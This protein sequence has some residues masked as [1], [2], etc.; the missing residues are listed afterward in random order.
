[1]AET[2]IEWAHFTFNPWRGCTKVSAGCQNCYADTMSK[3]NP[4]TLGVWGP[5]GKR[6]VAAE[7][8]WRLPLKWNREAAERQ[9]NHRLAVMTCRSE[10]D[11]V[12][13]YERPR[14]FCASL[15]DVFESWD[16]RIHDTSG[17]VMYRSA[18]GGWLSSGPS[19]HSSLMRIDDVRARLFRLIDSTPNL[20]WLLLTKR[21][22]NIRRMWLNSVGNGEYAHC[23]S[24]FGRRNVWLLTSVEDQENA[25]KR[26]PELLKCRDLAPVLGLSCEPL[27]GPVDLQRSCCLACPNRGKGC[28][29]GDK[30]TERLIVQSDEG[31][32]LQECYCSRLNKLHWVIAGGESGPGARQC[33][34][35]WIRSIVKQCAAAGVACFVKQLGSKIVIRNDS[36]SEWPRGGDGLLDCDDWRS[37]RTF[38]GDDAMVRSEDRKGGDPDEWPEDLRVREF[39]ERAG[40]KCQP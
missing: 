26:I 12:E 22:E 39:P 33:H 36:F 9:D 20:D 5:Q 18:T 2:K 15:A 11:S 35:G 30:T 10:Y 21:P 38:Q 40:V 14:V 34:V 24:E 8:Y 37:R 29:P 32:I 23:D 13:P 31:G 19:Q 1:M 27:L 17:N 28:L 4:G 7:S 25:D 3:R 16:G 6:V